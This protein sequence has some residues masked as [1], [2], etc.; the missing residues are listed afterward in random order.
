MDELQ[1][2]IHWRCLQREGGRE[3]GGDAVAENWAHSMGAS[4]NLGCSN[5]SPQNDCCVPGCKKN[6]AQLTET[7]P[8]E[9]ERGLEV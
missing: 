2:I 4:G 5:W 9:L 6:E 7:C 8:G 3:S 1:L